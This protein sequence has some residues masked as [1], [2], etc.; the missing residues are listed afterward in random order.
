MRDYGDV[1]NY[2]YISV[3]MSSDSEVK[4]LHYV[5]GC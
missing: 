2:V 4:G 5:F 1:V 3:D